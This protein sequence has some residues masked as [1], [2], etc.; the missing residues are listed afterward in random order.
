ME[1]SGL[2]WGEAD[3]SPA[4]GGEALAPGQGV[5]FLL[6]VWVTQGGEGGHGHLDTDT[7]RG[8]WLLPAE[9][10]GSP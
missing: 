10:S 2:C 4:P 1:S 6:G 9:T 7:A 5:L 3:F 8:L